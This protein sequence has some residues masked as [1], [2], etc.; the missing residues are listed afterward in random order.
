MRTISEHPATTRTTHPPASSRPV[1]IG[2]GRL[3][4]G[5]FFLMTG[6]VHLGM[7]SADPT[8]YRH[9]A[10]HALFGFV[11]DGWRDVF[12]AHA[13]FWGLCLMA[14][15]LTLGV[16]LLAGPRTAAVGW[17]GVIAFH[18]LLMLFGFGFWVWSVPALALLVHLARS[19]RRALADA[20]TARAVS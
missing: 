18:V 19:D 10:D 14:L 12:M 3:A 7:V 8:V 20:T 15:E 1:L 5:G 4:V 13:T 17:A 9:F 16:L 2:R 6:G 11:R